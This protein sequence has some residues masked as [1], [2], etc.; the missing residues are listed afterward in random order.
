MAGLRLT[1]WGDA[2]LGAACGLSIAGAAWTVAFAAPIREPGCWAALSVAGLLGLIRARG[3]GDVPTPLRWP[4]VHGILLLFGAG[5]AVLAHLLVVAPSGFRSRPRRGGDRILRAVL[6]AASGACSTLIAA[7]GYRALGGPV[8]FAW[9]TAATVALGGLV[10]LHTVM[11]RLG[12]AAA[13]AAEAV[14][15]DEDLGWPGWPRALGAHAGGAMVGAWTAL[16]FGAAEWRPWILIAGAAVLAVHAAARKRH[17]W[18]RVR[19]VDRSIARALAT[20]LS[21][22]PGA[23]GEWKRL[24]RVAL[25]LGRAAGLPPAELDDLEVAACLYHVDRAAVAAPAHAI[26]TFR[27]FGRQPVEA[28]D[29]AALLEALGLPE[30]TA[31]IVRHRHERW[32]GEGAPD[33]LAGVQIPRPARVL[34]VAA[35]FT[36]L[37]HAEDARPALSDARALADLREEVGRAFDVRLVD[38]LAAVLRSQGR[39]ADAEDPAR[40]DAPG[41]PGGEAPGAARLAAVQRELHALYEISRSVSYRLELEENLTLIVDKLALLVPFSTAVV[42]L[43]DDDRRTLRARF[44]RGHAADRLAQSVVRGGSFPSARAAAERRTIVGLAP[45]TPGPK[46]GTEWD[47]DGLLPD[48]DL[49]ML[50][51]A[52]AAPLVVAGRCLGTLTVY[53]RGERRFGT[54]ERHRLATVAGYVARAVNRADPA[55]PSYLQ[56]LTDPLTGLPNG[57]YLEIFAADLV[58]AS[59]GE[60]QGGYGL[61]GFRVVDLERVCERHGIAAAERLIGVVARRLASSCGPAEVPVRYGHDLFLVLTQGGD[62]AERVRRWGALLREVEGAP[63]ELQRGEHHR[64]RLASGHTACP[65]DAA[66]LSGLLQVLEARLGLA[67]ERGRTVV[68]F[69]LVRSAG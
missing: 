46:G 11:D 44:A 28:V 49:G 47:L 41:G 43:L 7:L 63:I 34:A 57:R 36:E 19:P 5:P 12:A 26:P 54:R 48:R 30:R 14:E 21:S 33:G 20:G 64:P 50:R 4:V 6:A 39:D 13:V 42:Y 2:L 69:R 16:A 32:D 59:P 40:G 51:A 3:A 62:P 22:D 45:G 38:A 60:R 58:P 10:A 25:D 35:R 1:R 27:R 67:L 61:L 24:Q 29:E 68:P 15:R 8:P 23:A 37:T 66:G 56:S 18:R 53:D 17:D 65:A 9:S 55:S 31:E 52:L